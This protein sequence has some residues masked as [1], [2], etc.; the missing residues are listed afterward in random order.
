MNLC[1]NAIQAIGNKEGLLQ[2]KLSSWHV[3][4]AMVEQCPDLTP[5]PYVCLSVQDTGVGMTREIINRI[6]DPY[7]TTKKNGEGNG[8]G[9]AIVQGLVK[10]HKG[11][12]FVYSEPDK[13]SIFQVFLPAIEQAN[14]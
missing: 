6:F 2:I 9:L 12:I 14:I 5:G 13:G 4:E 10:G 1:T 11:T 8:L 7:F 3:N